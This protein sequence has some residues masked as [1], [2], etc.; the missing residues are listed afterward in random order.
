MSTCMRKIILGVAVTLDG[1]IEGP[2][3]E[4][5]WCFTDQDYGMTPF[6]K[7]IDA[8]FFGR[9]SYEMMNSVEGAGPNPFGK[10]K[11]YVFSNTVPQNKYPGVEVISGD[12]KNKVDKIKSEKGLDIWLFGGG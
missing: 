5:D 6:L 3:G 9:K 7:R 8:I 1:L 2:N 10:K 4:Y 12:V 11:G